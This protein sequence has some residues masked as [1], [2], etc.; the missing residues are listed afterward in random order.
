[1]DIHEAVVCLANWRAETARLQAA[2][3][4]MMKAVTESPE[5]VRLGEEYVH[6]HQME[7]ETEDTVR[8]LAV[9][10]YNTTGDKAAHDAVTVRVYTTLTYEP[11][12]ALD[13][14]REHL[15]KALKLDKTAFEKVAK[16]A[17]LDFVEIAEEPRATIAQDLSAYL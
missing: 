13:Y 14:C 7:S 9:E 4:A 10:F 1:M 6:A 16:V 8:T 17:D 2:Q 11:S 15:P 5:Y 3:Q 12:E